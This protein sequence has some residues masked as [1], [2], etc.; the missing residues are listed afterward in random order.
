MTLYAQSVCSLGQRIIFPDVEI[1]FIAGG[2]S[3][4]IRVRR[5]TLRTEAAS[6]CRHWEVKGRNGQTTGKGPSVGAALIG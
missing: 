2:G 5:S 1:K 4:G 6:A 3:I